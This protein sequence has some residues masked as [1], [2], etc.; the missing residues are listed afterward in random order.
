MSP[1]PPL[2]L[3]EFGDM[4]LIEILRASWGITLRIGLAQNDWHPRH[5]STIAEIT[6]CD[7]SGYPGLLPIMGFAAAFLVGSIATMNA[8]LLTWTHNGGMIANWVN[9]YYVVDSGGNLLWGQRNEPAVLLDG[10]GQTFGVAPQFS[11][12]SRF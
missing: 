10:N 5:E 2:I 1:A 9:A 4:A 11:L 7:F 12:S 8:A 6:P 3:T